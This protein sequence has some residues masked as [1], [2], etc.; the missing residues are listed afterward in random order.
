ML[1]AREARLWC[2][3]L[4]TQLLLTFPEHDFSPLAPAFFS[5]L[6]PML[7]RLAS[8]YTQSAPGVLTLL[9]V[10]VQQSATLH[11]LKLSPLSPLPCAYAMLA[12]RAVAPAVVDVVLSLV[13]ALLDHI[14]Q[15]KS[16]LTSHPTP[17][18]EIVDV[19]STIS[20]KQ[21]QTA[22]GRDGE[23]E[24]EG[25]RQQV[26]EGAER[27]LHEHMPALLS[28]LHSRLKCKF[29]G[30]ASKALAAAGGGEAA[31]RELKLFT[32]LSSHVSSAE[33][34]EPLLELFLPF[35]KLK[36]TPRTERVKEQVLRLLD[37][38]LAV[39]RQPELHLRFLGVQYGTLRSRGAREALC[40]L[41][42]SLSQL[43][44]I[45]ELAHLAGL[46]QVASLLAR[47]HARVLAG[48]LA[49]ISLSRR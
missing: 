32:R 10:I 19:E 18:E 33:Q 3:K 16:E 46:Q 15:G 23:G 7:V 12:A 22:G 24:R 36:S 26:A 20:D 14:D 30:D 6:Q 8:H 43:P 48:H 34:A 2:V 35:L 29:A 17:E 44:H 39:V 41:F 49:L 25:F 11:L 1:Q 21:S 42:V 9:Q 5:C 28:H 45:L 31:T 47:C 4:L 40:R 27:L 13:E 38:L 37:G